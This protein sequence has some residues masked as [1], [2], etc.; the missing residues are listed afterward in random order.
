MSDVHLS[1]AEAAEMLGVH[2]QRIHQRIREGSLPA[3]KVGNQ[4][5]VEMNDLRRIRHHA[6]PGRP[7]SSKS[8][9]DLLAVAAR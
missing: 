8:A 2:P 3:E 6:G 4:W 1:V 5:A 7:L 9:W